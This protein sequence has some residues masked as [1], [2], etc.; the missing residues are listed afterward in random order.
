M[1]VYPLLLILLQMCELL[2]YVVL[3]N[4]I[5]QHQR[6]MV[7]HKII[8]R[9]M[10]NTRKGIHLIS[11]Y[12]QIYGFLAELIYLVGLFVIKILGQKL[13]F[14]NILELL[15]T[16]KTTEFEV[17]STIQIFMSPD[18]RKKVISTFRIYW[19]SFNLISLKYTNGNLIHQ[20]LLYKL[21]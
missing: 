5:N 4:Y 7:T 1:K 3:H 13:F 21:P 16:L 12:A 2:C 11:L 18:L 15:N 9:D 6:E 14:S 19:C 10:Y 20:Q 8:S 17:I